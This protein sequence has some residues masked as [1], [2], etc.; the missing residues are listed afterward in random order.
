MVPPFHTPLSEVPLQDLYNALESCIVPSS[1]SDVTFS[2]WARTFFCKPLI[3][4]EPEDDYQCELI[5]EIAR[6]EEKTVRAVGVGHSPSDLACTKEFMLRTR[7]LNRVLKVD[8]EKRRVV[9][10]GGITLNDLHIELAKHGLAMINVGSISDQTLAGIVTTAT[11]GSG[12]EYGVM[13]TH[14][15]S[16]TLL[17]ANGSYAY[18]SR[19]EKSDLFMAS[20]CGLGSTGFIT[21][22]ELEVEPAFRLKE[23]Q[24]SRSFEETMVDLEKVVHSAEHVRFYWFPA[25][26]TIRE[27]VLN[28]THEDK[29]LPYSWFWDTFLGY[30]AVQ[31]MLFVGRYWPSANNWTTRFAAWLV[32]SNSVSIDDS[33]RIFNFECRV[34]QSAAPIPINLTPPQYHQYTTEWAIPLSNAEACLRDLR[35]WWTQELKDPRGLRPH[36]PVEIRFSAADDIW[37]SPSNGQK[38]CWIGI[39]QYKPYGF[40]VPYRKLFEG[41]ERILSSHQGRPHW[42]KAH[43]FRP[44]DLRRAYSRFDSFVNVLD[45]VDPKGV[46]RNEYINRHIFGHPVDARVHKLRAQ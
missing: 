8:V 33:Y 44:E 5:L 10:Q 25:A 14:V 6:R 27:S 12:I 45:E 32:S 23:V 22:V 2:N 18:C 39:V 3:V 24:R 46:F 40:A 21:S 34:S 28:R 16:L 31:F 4:F 7:K 36:F 41:F 38:T 13:S 30:H 15:L 20:I 19:E 29:L 37:L 11:H 1:S 9:A 17:L 35:T 43:R 26:D 42:A